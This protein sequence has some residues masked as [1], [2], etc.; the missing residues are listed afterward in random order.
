MNFFNTVRTLRAICGKSLVHFHRTVM[1]AVNVDPKRSDEN[2]PQTPL[3][4]GGRGDFHGKKCP[5]F[6]DVIP[7]CFWRESRK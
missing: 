5:S 4:K 3:E 1:N 6:Q 7:A 2:T